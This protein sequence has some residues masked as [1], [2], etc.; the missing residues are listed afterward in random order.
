ML[1]S[2]PYFWLWLHKTGNNKTICEKLRRKVME[3]YQQLNSIKGICMHWQSTKK[4]IE[5]KTPRKLLRKQTI[6]TWDIKA[7]IGTEKKTKENQMEEIAFGSSH[8]MC[9]NVVS[10]WMKNDSW[11]INNVISENC[12]FFFIL[13]FIY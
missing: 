1:K 13:Q 6:C 12:F 11:M 4:R 9:V 5:K 7:R 8:F 3:K 10:I 2:A